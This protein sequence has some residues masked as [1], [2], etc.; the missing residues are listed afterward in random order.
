MHHESEVQ[1][2]I[3]K[4]MDIENSAKY[5]NHLYKLIFTQLSIKQGINKYPVEGEKSI[6][7]EFDNMVLRDV[8]SEVKYESSTS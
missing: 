2:Y 3:D 1:N 5:Q 4:L 8:F 7:K 6:M